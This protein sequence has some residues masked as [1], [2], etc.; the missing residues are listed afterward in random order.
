MASTGKKMT[1]DGSTHTHKIHCLESELIYKL[2]HGCGLTLVAD[3][4][5]QIMSHTFSPEKK[6]AL[7]SRCFCYHCAELLR[8]AT[9]ALPKP[10]VNKK[11]WEIRQRG[12]HQHP[13]L[14]T[15]EATSCQ[16]SVHL[17]PTDREIIGKAFQ[18]L[19]Q[20]FCE[21]DGRCTC[22]IMLLMFLRVTT[23]SQVRGHVT[24]PWRVKNHS[25]IIHL[26]VHTSAYCMN[27]WGHNSL[28]R[29]GLIP[30]IWSQEWYFGLGSQF[31]CGLK[32]WFKYAGII[33][34]P[35]HPW[36]LHL[37]NDVIFTLYILLTWKH[38]LYYRKWKLI[39]NIIY[40]YIKCMHIMK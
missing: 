19:L 33:E 2:L 1:I 34:N 15:T 10:S 12:S 23:M 40:I 24:P 25:E 8:S 11:G 30:S 35:D 13:R 9:K 29:N 5:C 18:L 16:T 36:P 39:C 20:A 14:E 32:P 27:T 31:T 7:C 4:A 22:S 21:R 17:S 38:Y 3:K 6:E 26:C 28:K 37:Q